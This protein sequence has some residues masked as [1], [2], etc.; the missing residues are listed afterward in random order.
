MN[1]PVGEGAGRTVPVGALH[2]VD[3]DEAEAG[4]RLR[5]ALVE[6]I[7][8]ERAVERDEVDVAVDGEVD[9]RTAQPGIE[10]RVGVGEEDPLAGGA[11]GA[12]PR[13][14]ALPR[15]FVGTGLVLDDDDPRI[16][17]GVGPDDLGGAIGAAV[18]H[19]DDL[20]IR[21]RLGP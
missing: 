17:G 20:E 8:G 11:S 2:G 13:G 10:D 9:R 6:A 15:P 14:V 5:N 7:T 21:P 4:D 12:D 3:L 1:W 16:L 18:E 19:E